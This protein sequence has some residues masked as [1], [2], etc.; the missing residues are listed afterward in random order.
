VLT[1]SPMLAMYASQ[2]ATQLSAMRVSE[3]EG[4]ARRRRLQEDDWQRTLG[5]KSETSCA[6]ATVACARWLAKASAQ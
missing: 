3:A 4:A 6:S 2:S 5:E 1:D